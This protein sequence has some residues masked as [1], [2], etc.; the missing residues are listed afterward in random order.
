M[1]AFFSGT[2]NQELYD[3]V[4][5]Y[6]YYLSL[7]V[8]T[9][10]Q[11]VARVC[12]LA[13]SSEDSIVANKNLDNFKITF[14]E[15]QMVFVYMD[16]EI[17][18]EKPT[19]SII[20]GLITKF[21]A[22]KVEKSKYVHHYPQGDYYGNKNYYDKT[23]SSK[24]KV[25]SFDKFKKNMSEGKRYRKLDKKD[26]KPEENLFGGNK[27]F[28]SDYNIR[29]TLCKMITLNPNN[30]VD[31]LF[32]L[33]TTL[34]TKYKT[35]QDWDLYLDKIED[36]MDDCM[37]EEF[38]F[39]GTLDA[40]ERLEICLEM[41]KKLECA[42]FNHLTIAKSIADM[43]YH[44]CLTEEPDEKPTDDDILQAIQD[45]INNPGDFMD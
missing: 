37:D 1:S 38:Q 17:L 12:Y 20:P 21:D 35:S 14:S 40:Q 19:V 32:N 18:F 31:D 39:Y 28:M 2:D 8:N 6:D 4:A 3:N 34:N 10:D 33:L 9:K 30:E 29:R 7:V 26:N 44:V 42:V 5:N 13:E 16:C 45:S 23:N 41:I 25:L 22:L 15:K 27:M 24:G 11:Y 36:C 43:I